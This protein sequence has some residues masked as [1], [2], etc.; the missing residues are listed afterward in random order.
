MVAATG[1]ELEA[2]RLSAGALALD[3][4]TRRIASEGGDILL[5]P[6][7]RHISRRPRLVLSVSWISWLYMKAQGSR[8]EFTPTPMIGWPIS[9]ER[10][11][12][13]L[14]LKSGNQPTPPLEKPP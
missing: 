11:T 13:Q 4:D 12:I 6:H 8:R 7:E 10:W 2:H 1:E 3:S 5:D 14:W 9:A